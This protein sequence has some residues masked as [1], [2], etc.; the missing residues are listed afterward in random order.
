MPTVPLRQSALHSEQVW[1]VHGGGVLYMEGAG[2]G[3]LY[4]DPAPL[5]DR[6]AWLKTLP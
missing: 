2:A 6:Q 5:T 1:N 4:M 3:T